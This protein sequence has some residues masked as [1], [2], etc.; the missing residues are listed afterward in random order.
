LAV[1]EAHRVAGPQRLD[2]GLAG[3]RGRGLLCVLGTPVR[4]RAL[5]K[6]RGTRALEPRK[7]GDAE[8]DQDEDDDQPFHAIA[9]LRP[10]ERAPPVPAPW[11]LTAFGAGWTFR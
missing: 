10:P 11:P 5:A 4:V 9:Y 3:G 7:A 1:P 6:G 8:P 2:R